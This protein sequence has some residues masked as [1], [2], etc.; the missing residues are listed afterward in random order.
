MASP[1]TEQ[2]EETTTITVSSIPT[3]LVTAIDE[4]APKENRNRSGLI[5]NRLREI[6][7]SAEPKKGVRR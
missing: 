2:V 6:F 5:V 7:K 1:E 4:Q 3:W